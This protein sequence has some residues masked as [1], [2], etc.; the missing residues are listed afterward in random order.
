MIIME[1]RVQIFM[2]HI[3][4]IPECQADKTLLVHLKV[5]HFLTSNSLPPTV[6]IPPVYLIIGVDKKWSPGIHFIIAMVM[7]NL[8]KKGHISICAWSIVSFKTRGPRKTKRVK[9]PGNLQVHIVAT[10]AILHI[11]FQNSFFSSVIRLWST[12]LEGVCTTSSVIVFV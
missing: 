10:I 3:H 9:L 2:Y 6:P 1:L 12:L 7:F 5:K 4:T 11:L 8:W